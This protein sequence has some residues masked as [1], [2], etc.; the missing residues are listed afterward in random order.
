MSCQ[1][2][3]SFAVSFTLQLVSDELDFLNED[4]LCTVWNFICNKQGGEPFSKSFA[5]ILR[6][7]TTCLDL[8]LATNSAKFTHTGS[9]YVEIGWMRKAH[10]QSS[11]AAEVSC[12][13]VRVAAA[14]LSRRSVCSQFSNQ[15][16]RHGQNDECLVEVAVYV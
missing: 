5:T 13:S 7:S 2:L 10:D 16:Q 9:R 1:L 8:N 12:V 14:L 15:S 6:I 3:V 4:V 11:P